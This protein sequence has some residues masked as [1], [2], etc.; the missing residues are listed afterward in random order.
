MLRRFMVIT[1][2]FPVS[3]TAVFGLLGCM[4]LNTTVTSV[5]HTSE[6]SEFVFILQTVIAATRE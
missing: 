5:I 4:A 2:I 6:D 1:R 3:L